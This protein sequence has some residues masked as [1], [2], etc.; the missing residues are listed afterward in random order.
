MGIPTFF[1]KIISEY[2]DTHFSWKELK[3]EDY[4]YLDFN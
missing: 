1:R 3:D 2:P 4:F